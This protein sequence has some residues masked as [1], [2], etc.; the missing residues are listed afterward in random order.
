MTLLQGSIEESWFGPL[1]H[2]SVLR[3]YEAIVPGSA[4]RIIRMA[5]ADTTQKADTDRLLAEGEVDAEKQGIALAFVLALAC[6][7]ASIVF[8]ALGNEIAGAV[9]VGLPLMTVIGSFIT[10]RSRSG[11]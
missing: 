10:G 8:F 9:L 11:S 6:I 2:P 7:I 1:P 5:E 3:E 4:E